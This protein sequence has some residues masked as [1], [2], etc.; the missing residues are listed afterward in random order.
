MVCGSSLMVIFPAKP[1]HISV[2]KMRKSKCQNCSVSPQAELESKPRIPKCPAQGPL[3]SLQVMRYRCANRLAT[4]HQH[5]NPTPTNGAQSPQEMCS[6]GWLSLVSWQGLME[7]WVVLK[8]LGFVVHAVWTHG[9]RHR[10]RIELGVFSPSLRFFRRPVNT[11]FCILMSASCIPIIQ[12]LWKSWPWLIIFSILRPR[13]FVVS[14]PVT[15]YVRLQRASA[16][17]WIA[18]SQLKLL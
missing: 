6:S 5:A 3:L 7:A 16:T 14:P 1:A 10:H 12:L 18:W 15:M 4:L 2:L 9:S 8:K 11:L 13:L 17:S